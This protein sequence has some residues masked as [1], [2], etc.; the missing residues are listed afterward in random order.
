M[1]A[2]GIGVFNRKGHRGRGGE[3]VNH[4]V[5]FVFLPFAH[6]FFDP[7]LLAHLSSFQATSAAHVLSLYLDR[8]THMPFHR[9]KHLSALIQQCTVPVPLRYL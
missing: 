6:R 4:S 9:R 1:V 3:G 7:S 8:S 2:G 5:G